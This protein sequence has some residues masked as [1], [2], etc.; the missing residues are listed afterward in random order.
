MDNAKAE[1]SAITIKRRVWG[2]GIA[3]TVIVVLNGVP[4]RMTTTRTRTTS[5]STTV[6]GNSAMACDRVETFA[7]NARNAV[8]DRVEREHS[9]VPIVRRRRRQQH[10][11]L[12][13]ATFLLLLLL[14]RR[15]SMCQRRRSRQRLPY[16]S[17]VAWSRRLVP[18]AVLQ[19]YSQQ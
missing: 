15:E 3:T 16:L 5:M 6:T 1:N 4:L 9:G 17:V 7:T 13:V 14:R 18:Q 8:S 12:V 19:E 2:V 10:Q 11:Q